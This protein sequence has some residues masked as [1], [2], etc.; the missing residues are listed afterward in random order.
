MGFNA[1]VNFIVVYLFQ[2]SG[3][4]QHEVADDKNLVGFAQLTIQ[5][6]NEAN[7]TEQQS[8]QSS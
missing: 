7:G 2:N 6:P 8:E 1:A 5:D 4:G 3:Y